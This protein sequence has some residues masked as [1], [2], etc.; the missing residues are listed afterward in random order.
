MIRIAGS[1]RLLFLVF[2]LV[3]Q[4]SFQRECDSD[5]ECGIQWPESKCS[6]GKCRCPPNF[7][8]RASESRGWV[9]LSLNDAVTGQL[10][11]P[12]VC[13]LPSGAGYR[14]VLKD[15]NNSVVF[16]NTKNNS[17][18]CGNS[19]ECIRTIG[20]LSAENDGVCC[21]QK[22]NSCDPKTVNLDDGGWLTRWFF[23]G[24]ECVKF[25]WN[26]ETTRSPNTF[27]SKQHCQSYCQ[28]KSAKL[29]RLFKA[30][31]AF[32]PS[33]ICA[34]G[35]AGNFLA[36]YL[37]CVVLIGFPITYLHL[38]LGQFSG[39][40]PTEVFAKLCP[41]F[42]G[43]GWSWLVL[44]IPV[45][46]ISNI[47]STWAL[48]YSFESFKAFIT[49]TPLP[50]S[51]QHRIF[52]PTQEVNGPLLEFY[53]IADQEQVNNATT[54]K[55]ASLRE[56]FK[57]FPTT[58]NYFHHLYHTQSPEIVMAVE[59]DMLRIVDK[60]IV[61]GKMQTKMIVFLALSWLIV[62]LSTM[63]NSVNTMNKIVYVTATL[64][65]LFL[66]ILLIRVVYLP[67]AWDGIRL[68][69]PTVQRIMEK[70]L[71]QRATKLIFFDMQ[72]SVG[73]LISI[74]KHNRFHNNIFRDSI[75][76]VVINVIV[77]LLCA[78]VA[79]AC[80]GF[81]AYNLDDKDVR[82]M[83]RG[84]TGPH[85][86]WDQILRSMSYLDANEGPIF[87]FLYQ[88]MVALSAIECSFTICEYFASSLDH[89]IPW[90]KKNHSFI[91]RGLVS[92]VMCCC[93]LPLCFQSGVQIYN[94]LVH[95]SMHWN[96]KLIALFQ[97]LV[98]GY[99]YG[100]DNLMFDIRV[101][102]RLPAEECQGTISRFLGPTGYFIRSC[103][104]WISPLLILFALIL[105]LFTNDGRKSKRIGDSHIWHVI[106]VVSTIPILSFIY[107]IYSKNKDAFK[108][109][110]WAN[111]QIPID[112][113]TI[114]NGALLQPPE[115]ESIQIEQRPILNTETNYTEP[116]PKARTYYPVNFVLNNSPYFTA[117]SAP[118]Y[119]ES[120]DE[121]ENDQT[122]NEEND[123][124]SEHDNENEHQIESTGETK[125][126]Q[127]E[128]S[129][130]IC[131]DDENDEQHECS[132]IP[133]NNFFSLSGQPS[134]I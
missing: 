118:A 107:F 62:T 82:S 126:H 44:T 111:L 113:S 95:Y 43:I 58:P 31:M 88:F 22:N 10:G 65:L 128:D 90:L 63:H 119:F 24:T 67:G 4:S 125:S 52:L 23:N 72:I 13:P 73:V 104:K 70:S 64:P 36:V 54:I 12:I 28:T 11:P 6:N 112:E 124:E 17:T 30:N 101:M 115:L 86:L 1:S 41:A 77:N 56:P 20:I 134:F 89:K 60:K 116:P 81:L 122:T 117:P 18:T 66:F 19:Y 121:T 26:P 55:P 21:P 37:I 98:I 35:H 80:L 78:C 29:S 38:A 15:A 68:L 61:L 45:L 51:Y 25:M 97:F 131:S 102:L 14:V 59:N 42:R 8:R 3:V 106:S 85:L 129:T 39:Y 130:D 33:A 47:N 110:K 53:Q 2:S 105:D 127:E 103:W 75:L 132:D 46:I 40:N 120:N 114:N 69:Y 76:L 79:F 93:T 50:W 9:C 74:S 32:F 49:E 57:I 48:Y 16:C 100:V 87:C 123:R 109:K 99:F 34:Q 84:Q 108:S 5:K 7:I 94:L 96:V 71:W 27:L 91:L 133:S 92:L 83:C